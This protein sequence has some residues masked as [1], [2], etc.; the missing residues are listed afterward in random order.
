VGSRP[1][2]LDLNACGKDVED[3]EHDNVINNVGIIG[4]VDG[5]YRLD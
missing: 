3:K 2:T 4:V 1:F 5:V